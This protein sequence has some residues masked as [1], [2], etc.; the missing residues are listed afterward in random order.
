[1]D[2]NICPYL[3]L[4]DDP[5]TW[6]SYPSEG[7]ACHAK[8][9]SIPVILTY[10]RD[11]CFRAEHT[12]C[13]GFINGWKNGFPKSLRRGS[14]PISEYFQ[15][16]WVWAALLGII[17]VIAGVL[18]YRQIFNFGRNVLASFARP[19]ETPTPTFTLV[20]TDTPTLTPTLTLTYTATV[21]ETPAITDT[22][23]ITLTPTETVTETP[24]PTNTIYIPPYVP[25]TS[26]PTKKPSRTPEPEPTEAPAPTKKPSSTPTKSDK[27]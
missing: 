21:T 3:G 2:E 25:P 15:K 11:Y 14:P 12:E 1:M 24:T 4:I 19:T 16:K 27:P 22:A 8:N 23:T 20:P 17:L 18:F 13:P 5:K 10:Q 26:T 7:N 6:T 9:K